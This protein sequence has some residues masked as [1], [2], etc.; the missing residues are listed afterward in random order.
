MDT[1][2]TKTREILPAISERGIVHR[3][4]AIDISPR[5]MAKNE[6]SQQTLRAPKRALNHL[7][8]LN[9]VVL[10][11]PRCAPKERNHHSKSD[12][13]K[14][15]AHGPVRACTPELFTTRK[16]KG[17]SGKPSP[18]IRLSARLHRGKPQ[19]H[20]HRGQLPLVTGH[21]SP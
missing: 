5:S 15:F 14:Y 11:G 20:A 12:Q 13:R 8:Y 19:A 6:T 1:T 7:Q 16:S 21:Y 9:E 10:R 17:R 18:R 3:L 4:R 2:R